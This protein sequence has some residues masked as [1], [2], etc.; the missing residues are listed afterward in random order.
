VAVKTNAV[1]LILLMSA[2]SGLATE[3]GFARYQL[4]I[5]KHPFGE[6]PPEAETVQIPLNQSFARHLRLSMLFE[7][8]GGDVRAGIID[9]KEKKN[10]ILSIGEVEGGLELIEAD[11]SASEA[12]LRKGSE[13]ALFKLESDTPE[14]LSKSQQAARRSSYA[15][16]RSARLAAAN[17]STKPKKPEAPRLTGEALRAHLENVQM[18]A[19]RD[20][21]PPLPLPLT[22]EMDAQ[23]VAEGVLDPQ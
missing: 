20:G 14:P 18:N 3:D 6:E 23:L 9:T 1:I 8:P 15:G 12:M 10:Y 22:P 17:K 11:L 5:D 21:L 19:I 2:L 16:R 4:I 13:V 7:G